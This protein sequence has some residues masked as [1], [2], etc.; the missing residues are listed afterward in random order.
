M[1]IKELISIL[2]TFP[3]H[4]EVW[5]EGCDCSGK[6]NGVKKSTPGEVLITRGDV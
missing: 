1:T 2:D 5:I 3:S 6:A 4:M